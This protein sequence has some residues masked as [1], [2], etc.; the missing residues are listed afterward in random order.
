[1]VRV[2]TILSGSP[3]KEIRMVAP[4]MGISP[5]LAVT[6]ICN[7][8]VEAPVW[9]GKTA[10]WEETGALSA[11]GSGDC[12]GVGAA[13]DCVWEAGSGFVSKVG[14]EGISVLFKCG[15][16]IKL[17]RW[18]FFYRN[19]SEPRGSESSLLFILCRMKQNANYAIMSPIEKQAAAKQTF[20]FLGS[21][22][23]EQSAQA[24]REREARV[25]E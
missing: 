17:P 18:I 22:T 7:R 8:P 19:G 23:R 5:M 1:M 24:D 12:S 21:L 25:R 20:V 14:T 9:A 2:S 3:V 16:S 4:G 10:G 6:S 11:A 15:F 13:A